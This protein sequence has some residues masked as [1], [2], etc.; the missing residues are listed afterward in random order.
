MSQQRYIVLNNRKFVN[1]VTI[2]ETKNKILVSC[3]ETE[4]LEILMHGI[5]ERK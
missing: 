5:I 2:L 1:H 4:P 3:K